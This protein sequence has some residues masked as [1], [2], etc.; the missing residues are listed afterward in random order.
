MTWMILLAV[1]NLT[2]EST[3]NTNT[4][5][6]E[7]PFFPDH[8]SFSDTLGIIS[9]ILAIASIILSFVIYK[10]SN[11]TSEKLAEDAARRAFEKHYNIGQ[12]TK[13]LTEHTDAN[14]LTKE[15]RKSVKKSINQL[16]KKSKK[17]SATKPW[18]HAASFP[19]QLKNFFDEEATVHL[20]YKW[21]DKKFI[22]WNGSLENSTK[23][24]ILKGDLIIE[25]IDS[26]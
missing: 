23:V 26:C 19:I 16:I 18:I 12:P 13:K 21:R 15:Q 2:Q 10:L 1:N 6:F 17:N 5:I 9:I 14:I 20:M 25:D 3:E 7:S 8:I 11:D 4:S 22:N 24:Y